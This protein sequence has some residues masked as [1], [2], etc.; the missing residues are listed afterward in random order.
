ME[1]APSNYLNGVVLGLAAVSIWARWSAI[2]RLAVTMTLG[3]WDIAT[4]RFGV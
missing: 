3:A 4:L 2:T 1:Q